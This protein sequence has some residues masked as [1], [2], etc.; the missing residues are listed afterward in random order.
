MLRPSR[1]EWDH[2]WSSKILDNLLIMPG[3]ENN[4]SKANIIIHIFYKSLVYFTKQKQ[5]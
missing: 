1:D 3:P 5:F 2:D 4:P